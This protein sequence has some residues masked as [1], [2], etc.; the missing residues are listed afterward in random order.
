MKD[1]TGSEDIGFCDD[2]ETIRP[3]DNMYLLIDNKYLCGICFQV[4]VEEIRENDAFVN[5]HNLLKHPPS[6]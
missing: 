5:I 4:V 1:S 3:T 6:L 2:C